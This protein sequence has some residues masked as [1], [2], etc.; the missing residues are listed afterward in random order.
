[1][2]YA[3]VLALGHWQNPVH[4]SQSVLSQK[5]KKNSSVVWTKWKYNISKIIMLAI[6]EI[7]TM[8]WDTCLFRSRLLNK[9]RQMC[10]IF[11]DIMANFN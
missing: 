3:N 11:F 8:A 6:E 1:M 2:D 4:E 10:S 7:F 9:A 5:K